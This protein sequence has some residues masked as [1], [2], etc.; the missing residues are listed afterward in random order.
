M[1][2]LFGDDEEEE[3]GPMEEDFEA[4]AQPESASALGARSSTEAELSEPAALRPRLEEAS[5]T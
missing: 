5:L 1:R 3:V 2:E 4:S